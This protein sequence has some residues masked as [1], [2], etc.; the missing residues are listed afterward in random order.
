MART[1]TKTKIADDIKP[2]DTAL[3]KAAAEN[4]WDEATQRLVLLAFI[5]GANDAWSA[6]VADFAEFL[7]AAGK[8]EPANIL[9]RPTRPIY[10]GERAEDDED[11]E[12][13]E[14][15]DLDD[16]E[17]DDLDDEEDDFDDDL[18]DDLDDDDDDDDFD[19][20]DD[21]DDDFDDEE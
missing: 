2:F 15:D 6:T 14:E 19:D 3:R 9:G 5:S 13:E 4:G 17:D 20:E 18:D 11:D 12:D 10:H 1:L 21:D 8:D 7:A 16:D